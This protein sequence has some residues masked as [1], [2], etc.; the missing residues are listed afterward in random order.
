MNQLDLIDI[1]REIF[2]SSQRLS[3]AS[4]EIFSIAKEKAET[5]R[6]YR[7][8]LA[9]EKIR[10]RE[11][12]MPVSMIND[13]ARGNL[14]DLLFERDLAETKYVAARDSMKAIQSQ[15]SALQSILRSQEEI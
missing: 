5:E 11:Q 15:L 13:V 12:N 2:K 4:Q 1:K 9:K 3:R 8:E 7:R 10:L 14:S 6:K